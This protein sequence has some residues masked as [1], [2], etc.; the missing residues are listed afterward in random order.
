[1]A[2]EKNLLIVSNEGGSARSLI[3]EI[4]FTHLFK[5]RKAAGIIL[6]GPVRDFDAVPYPIY[7]TGSNPGGPYKEGP[8]EINVPVS[9]GDACVFPG[10]IV[11]ADCD[12]V[13]VV[14]RADAVETLEKAM[15]Y[16]SADQKKLQA[17]QEG[18]ANRAWVQKKIEE[19]CFE[20]II[21]NGFYCRWTAF[22][23]PSRTV[24]FKKT[25]GAHRAQR[26]RG[27]AKFVFPLFLCAIK[28]MVLCLF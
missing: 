13:V 21:I 14:P 8:G 2:D 28:E 5:N 18:T 11:V 17:A 16:R 19:K 22:S 6:D 25:M 27:N 15:A 12:G 24:P 10:D 20:I 9:C 3:G 26:K 1:M 4:M 23:A 7:A